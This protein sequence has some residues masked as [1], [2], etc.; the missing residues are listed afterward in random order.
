[1]QTADERILNKEYSLYTDIG[2][3]GPTEGLLG[4]KG[5]R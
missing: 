1:M 3:T 2:M 4:W 5:K